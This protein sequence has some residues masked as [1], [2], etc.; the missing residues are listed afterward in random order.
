MTQ[1]RSH[2]G[3]GVPVDPQRA[4]RYDRTADDPMPNGAGG[5]AAADT[6]ILPDPPASEAEIQGFGMKIFLASLTMVFMGTFV[7]YGVIWWRNRDGWDRVVDRGELLGL[8]AAT[9]LLVVADVCAARALKAAENQARAW[10][11]TRLTV[12]SATIYLV[13]QSL[14]WVPLL[15]AVD[16]RPGAENGLGMEGFLFLMLTL[17]H[18]VHVLGGIIANFMVLLRSRKGGGPAVGSLRLL[19]QYWRFLTVVWVAVLGLLLAF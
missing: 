18:A 14:S 9:V 10:S 16:R 4:A 11:L 3:P 8:A 15:E 12:I 13:V 17:A 7:A 1:R 6:R 5:A 19:Y 2:L